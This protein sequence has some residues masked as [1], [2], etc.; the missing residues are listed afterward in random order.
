MHATDFSAEWDARDELVEQMKRENCL[1]KRMLYVRKD[2][3]GALALGLLPKQAGIALVEWH[4]NTYKLTLVRE[5]QLTA[6]PFEQKA[7]GFG[8]VFG[9]GEKGAIGWQL[10]VF[11][12][13]EALAEVTLLPAITAFADLLPPD[14]RF[15]YGRRKP[16]QIPLWQLKPEESSFC[17]T[18]VSLWVRL[19]S[20]SIS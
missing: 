18:V 13:G 10:C 14:D 15:F 8:G 5:P 3:G 9:L 19:V 7:D 12:R 20:E 17:E 4:T 6:E 16:R 1:P 2:D 11:E